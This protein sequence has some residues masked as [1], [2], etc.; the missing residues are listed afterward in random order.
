[1]EPPASRP[2]SKKEPRL[3]P[4]SLRYPDPLAHRVAIP[5][6]PCPRFRRAGRRAPECPARPQRRGGQKEAQ[7]QGQ[8]VQVTEEKMRCQCVAVQSDPQHCGSCGHECAA[9]ESCQSG[10]CT[11]VSCPT[12]QHDCGNQ[13]C[14]QCCANSHCGSSQHC[15]LTSGACVCLSQLHTCNDPYVCWSCCT[16]AHC[17]AYHKAPEDGFICTVQHACVCQAGS[18]CMKADL[19]G[20]FCADLQND[21]DNC[22][23]CG[24]NCQSWNCIDGTCTSP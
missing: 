16:D 6:R 18:E 14:R 23:E 9:G 17:R 4:N 21:H 1:M 12:G 24:F 7:A 13:G 5:P 15:D 11:I 22:G 8:E 10:V 2:A 19:S 20:Y 3:G